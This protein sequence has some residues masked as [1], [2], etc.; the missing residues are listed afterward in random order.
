MKQFLCSNCHAIYEGIVEIDIEKGIKWR[1][2]QIESILK[3]YGSLAVRKGNTIF[4]GNRATYD[5][6]E[7]GIKN[8][9]YNLYMEQF[10]KKKYTICE[11]CEQVNYFL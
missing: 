1:E 5:Y 4:L 2:E 11:V 7:E 6:T 9:Q 10:L 8:N 3:H